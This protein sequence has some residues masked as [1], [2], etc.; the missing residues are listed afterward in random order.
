MLIFILMFLCKTFY[1]LNHHINIV[2]IEYVNMN[3]LNS[4]L[5]DR[6][7]YVNYNSSQSI[8]KMVTKGVPQGSIFGPFIFYYLH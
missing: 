5:F 1:M 3:I 2:S 8:S 4:N 7:Q 6:Y